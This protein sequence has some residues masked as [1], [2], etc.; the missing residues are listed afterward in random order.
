[1]L[2]PS[3]VAQ[4]SSRPNKIVCSCVCLLTHVRYELLTPGLIPKGFMDGRKSAVMMVSIGSG[5]L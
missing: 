3:S 2:S 1:M 5:C 4:L